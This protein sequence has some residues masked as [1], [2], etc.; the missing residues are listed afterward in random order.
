MSRSV[1]FSYGE[2]SQS[3]ASSTDPGFFSWPNARYGR[4]DR[5]SHDNSDRVERH[6]SDQGLCLF[7]TLTRMYSRRIQLLPNTWAGIV[8]LVLI[9]EQ[10]AVSL[11]ELYRLVERQATPD[12][13]ANNP[14]W[15]ATVRRTLQTLRKK[16][17]TVQV[18]KA[19]WM[20]QLTDQSATE[21]P[22][23]AGQ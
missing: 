13:L 21:P 6:D 16:G 4:A 7:I 23:A 10:R 22:T 14:T 12:R 1:A 18:A 8:L 5:S 9:N 19:V 2:K 3:D 15:R 17:R 20:Y 11:P